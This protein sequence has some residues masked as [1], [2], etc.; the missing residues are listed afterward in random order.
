MHR[1]LINTQRNGEISY[2]F[3]GRL[4]IGDVERSK[5]NPQA[6]DSTNQNPEG[7]MTLVYKQPKNWPENIR[8]QRQCWTEEKLEIVAYRGSNSFVQELKKS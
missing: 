5:D 6:Y 3:S 2:I 4:L 7:T 8:A 1:K